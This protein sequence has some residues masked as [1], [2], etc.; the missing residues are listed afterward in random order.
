MKKVLC[1]GDSNTYGFIPESGR[2]YDKCTRWTGALAALGQNK[3]QII[4]AG[5]NNRTG[6]VDNSAGEAQTGY[7]ILPSLLNQPYDIVI[8]AIGINDIQFLYNTSLDDV[9]SGIENLINIVH[10]HCPEACVVVA[11]PSVLSEDVLKGYFSGMF[12]ET[13][14]EKS[15]H[16]SSIYKAVAQKSGAVFVD[17]N[18]FV[19][20]SPIDG[21]HY[22]A[23]SHKKIAAVMFDTLACLI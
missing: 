22:S 1:F 11:S 10:K 18:D 12:D 14:I 7:K 23:E 13:S 16:F 17:L 21:L 19:K 6:F 3:F 5:C 20:V 15:K 4:E 2:R 9:R 8:L